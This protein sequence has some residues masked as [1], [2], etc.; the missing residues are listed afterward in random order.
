M[1]MINK[2]IKKKKGTIYNVS[3]IIK[4]YSIKYIQ[5]FKIYQHVITTCSGGRMEKPESGTGTGTGTG[6]GNGT[7]T[8]TFF[9]VRLS[10]GRC[11]Y[12]TKHICFCF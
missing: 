12:Y 11:S 4:Y 5:C 1:K 8:G 6:T 9:S 10:L 3:K 7:G 2:N